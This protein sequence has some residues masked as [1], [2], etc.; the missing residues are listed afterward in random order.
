MNTIRDEGAY[1]IPI[2]SKTL[3]VLELLEEQKQPLALEQVHQ[4]TSISKTTVFRILRTLVHRGYVSRSGDGRY[5]LASRPKTLRFGFGGQSG[6]LPF[7]VAVTESLRAAAIGAGI[8]LLVVDNC[9]DGEAARK[10]VD[11]FIQERVDLVIEFQTDRNVAPIIADRL[12]AAGIPLIAVD[13]PHPN[14]IYF[15]VDNYRSGL[16]A[17]DLLGALALHRF[18]GNVDCVI[19]L[20][21]EKAGSLVQSRITGAF[22]GLRERIEHLPSE[23]F[24]RLDSH[25]LREE[26]FAVM[27]AF[28]RKNRKARRILLAAVNDTAA[29][30]AI[31]A[32]REMGRDQ[33]LCVVSHDC[34]EEAIVEMRCRKSPLVASV[35]HEVASY[36]PSLIQLGMA[37]LRG[38]RIPSYNYV[39]HRMVRG[40]SLLEAS[41]N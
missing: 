12:S 11:R 25:G 30:G 41:R 1:L 33:H 16:D 15:G 36:G 27:H 21:L 38:E 17:G 40:S 29:L 37:K 28:L 26:S 7:S 39:E 23:K 5:I 3:D 34:I 35:S 6:Q 18:K 20:D 14:A 8:D 22:E 13:I 2:V 4:R 9:Y 10:N 19:G 32:A 31:Q 24:V